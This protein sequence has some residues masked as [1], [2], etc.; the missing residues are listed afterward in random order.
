MFLMGEMN[1]PERRTW[2]MDQN[3]EGGIDIYYK[4]TSGAMMIKLEDEEIVVN[5]MGSRPS[6]DYL[7]GETLIINGMLDQ[8]DE[9]AFDNS[10]DEKDRLILL[11]EPG[12]AIDVV[13]ESL[14]FN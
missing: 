11:H 14:S 2:R 12:D 3:E 4:D 7:M 9:I 13:R 6:M 10:I 1:N 8:L 5:R